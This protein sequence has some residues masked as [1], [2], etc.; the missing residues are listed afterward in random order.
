[1]PPLQ[2]LGIPGG[3]LVVLLGTVVA[4]LLVLALSLWTYR[5]AQKNSSQSPVLWALVVF[6]A[7]LLGI[8][9]YLLLGRDRAAPRR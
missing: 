9:L 3:A 4:V 2:T 7:P 5:D 6:L 8:L 1:M